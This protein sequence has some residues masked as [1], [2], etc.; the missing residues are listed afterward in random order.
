MHLTESYVQHTDKNA[1]N[2]EKLDTS[3]LNV[4]VS[5]RM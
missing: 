2:V 5:L 4:A 3:Q 1:R